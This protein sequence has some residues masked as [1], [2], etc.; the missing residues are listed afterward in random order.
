MIS[1]GMLV[2]KTYSYNSVYRLVQTWYDTS[3]I[4]LAHVARNVIDTRTHEELRRVWYFFWTIVHEFSL[5]DL[6]VLP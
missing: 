4:V 5:L 3:I 2:A 1:Y 6:P